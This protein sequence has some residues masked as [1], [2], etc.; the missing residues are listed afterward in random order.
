MN[1]ATHIFGIEE[2]SEV[3]PPAKKKAVISKLWASLNK[4]FG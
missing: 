2:N 1:V 4:H 3:S